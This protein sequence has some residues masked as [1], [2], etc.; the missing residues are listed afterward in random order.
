MGVVKR[1]RLLALIIPTL[2]KSENAEL[3]NPFLDAVKESMGEDFAHEFGAMKQRYDEYYAKLREQ[4]R[5]LTPLTDD[6]IAEEVACDWAGRHVLTDADAIRR[7]V[8]NAE[9]A[10]NDP[11]TIISRVL[12]WIKDKINAIRRGTGIGSKD[13]L[14]ALEKAQKLWQDMYDVATARQNEKVIGK[15][16]SQPLDDTQNTTILTEKEFAP[17]IPSGQEEAKGFI[18]RV[19]EKAKIFSGGVFRRII[20]GITKRQAND[21]AHIGISIDSDYV[22]SVENTAILHNQKKHGNPATEAKRGQIAIIEEDYLLIPDILENYD[23]IEK[24]S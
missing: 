14:A 16:D 15:E 17:T 19:I 20:S 4:G 7:I 6:E 13:D 9:K 5:E 3:W 2:L 22:H 11:R 21:Y 8:E 12:D 10:G 24:S 23:N 18:Q 1:L